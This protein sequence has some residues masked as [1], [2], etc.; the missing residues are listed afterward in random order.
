MALRR[1]AGYAA[2]HKVPLIVGLT[3]SALSTV[4]SVLVPQVARLIVDSLVRKSLSDLQVYV[5]AIVGLIVAS[6]VFW[7]LERVEARKLAELVAA[8]LRV[9]LYA[10]MQE[11]PLSFIYR[12]GAG[13]LMSRATADLEEVKRLFLFFMMAFI[14]SLF[15]L[16]FSLASMLTIDPLVAAA[17]YLALSPL[18]FI[19]RSFAK[20]IRLKFREAREVY[21]EITS[22]LRETIVGILAVKALA[23]E[24]RLGRRLSGRLEKYWGEMYRIGLLRALVWSSFVI[25]GGLSFAV[26]YYLGGQKVLAGELTVGDVVA[27][28]LYSTMLTWPMASMG[29][30]V[31]RVEL[32]RVAAQRVFEILD[33][34]EEV[35][36]AP[37]AQPLEV[38]EGRVEF[39]DVW[40][41]YDG[42]RWVLKGLNLEVKPGEV[43]AITGP[44]GSGKSSL[45]M[46]LLRLYDPQKG[47]VLIDGVD[48]RRVKLSSLRSQVGLVHQDIYLFPGTIGENIAYAKPDASREE[49]ERAAR[50]AN[51]HDFIESLP[52]GYDTP[53]G[54]GGVTLSGGQRQRVAIARTLLANPKIIVLDDSTSEVDAETE[55]A[56]YDA[57]TKHFKGRTIIVVTQRPSTMRLADRVVV[58]R[59]GRV[60]YQG[61]PEDVIRRLMR[62]GVEVKQSNR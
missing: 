48:I 41:S 13:Q 15:T 17:S 14:S 42:D 10:K 5:A 29:L 55:K 37:D 59:D 2:R 4:F 43:L 6:G 22:I 56:I 54:E 44:P 51:I 40:F 27:L 45:A 62:R 9:E 52:R 32:S 61:K 53:V 16:L 58:L 57:L 31:T 30:A 19:F 50:L 8:D 1:L 11:L 28:G 35:E 38:K 39:R 36:E 25:L 21:G 3:A 47:Q 33:A 24:E 49:I 23:A 12:K 46:L 20:R 34:R 26:I 7:Y 18:P 60:A